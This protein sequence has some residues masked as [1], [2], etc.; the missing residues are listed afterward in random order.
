MGLYYSDIECR[1]CGATWTVKAYEREGLFPERWRTSDAH[2]GGCSEADLWIV[3]E[4]LRFVEH[5]KP[6]TVYSQILRRLETLGVGTWNFTPDETLARDYDPPRC[7]CRLPRLH[8]EVTSVTAIIRRDPKY[9]AWWEWEIHRTG[10]L[11]PQPKVE[12][13]S[14]HGD[15]ESAALSV[16]ASARACPTDMTGPEDPRPKKHLRGIFEPGKTRCTL[17]IEG[18]WEKNRVVDDLRRVTCRRCISYGL[19]PYY[20][21]GYETT[22]KDVEVIRLPVGEGWTVRCAQCDARLDV[23]DPGSDYVTPF[24]VVQATV[25]A[26]SLSHSIIDVESESVST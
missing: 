18:H 12:T 7:T 3:D 11:S 16:D 17:R 9:A 15:L 23:G 1:T 21:P 22:I 6:L 2:F 5:P 4:V 25:K 20:T 13:S 19:Q 26:H 14:F 10:V 24:Q 8:T